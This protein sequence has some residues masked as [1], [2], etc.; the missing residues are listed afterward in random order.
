MLRKRLFNLFSIVVAAVCLL[1]AASGCT[2]IQNAKNAIPSPI[3][4]PTLNLWDEGPLTLDPAISSEMSSHIYV[5]HI[6]S[7]LVKFDSELKPVGDI[8]DNWSISAD[9]KTYTF[10][11]RKDVKFHDGRPLTAQDIKYSLE[12]ACNPATGSQTASTYLNDIVG[13]PQMIRG[14]AD[15]LSGV[16]VLDDYTL[17]ISIDA[18]KAYFISKLAYPTAFAVDK[19]NVESGPDWWKKPVGTGPYKLTKW[20]EGSLILLQPNEDYYGKKGTVNVAFTLLAGLPMSLYET[21]KIDVVD[22]YKNNIDRALDKEGP[23]YDQ[24]HIYPEFSLQYI[25]FNASKPPFDDPYVRQAFCYAVNKGRIISVL[26]KNMVAAAEGIIPPGMPGYN[27]DIKGLDFDPAKARELLAKS[28]Y[29]SADKLPPITMTV[30]GAGANID[31][32]LGAILLDWKQNLGVTVNVRLLDPLIFNYH[33]LDEGDEIFTLGWIADYPDPQNFLNTLF[34][35][36]GQYN[37]SHYSNKDLDALLDRAAVE[38]DQA[39]RTALYQQAEQLVVEQAP[40]LPLWF[41]K[42]YVLVNPRVHGY[43]IDPLGVPRFNLVTLGQP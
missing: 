41:G 28:K 11:L 6:F 8:A 10:Y 17:T 30:P 5:M 13:A 14:K 20:D 31:D 37:N 26:Q 2:Q 36:N 42:N 4:G 38:M 16:T 29:G 43:D 9:G 25:G 1:A 24:L 19:K 12:R 27:K 18:P 22:V 3:S 35:T 7:G 40:V 23:L 15:N 33:L 32:F 21:G 39:K 34:Y